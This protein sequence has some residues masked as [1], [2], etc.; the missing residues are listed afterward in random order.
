MSF[1]KI[2]R[3]S[4]EKLKTF[5]GRENDN[6]EIKPTILFPTKRKVENAKDFKVKVI[7]QNEFLKMLNKTS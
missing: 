7:S 6:S 3:S 2:T 5:I 1:G 4:L